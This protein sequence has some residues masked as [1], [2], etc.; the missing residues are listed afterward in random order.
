LSQWN[1]DHDWEAVL[2]LDRRLAA[3]WEEAR[4]RQALERRATLESATLEALQ[5]HQFVESWVEYP[6][7]EAI[8]GT[9]AILEELL[10]ELGTEDCVQ[11]EA[12][13][14][15]VLAL[16]ALDAKLKYFIETM[17]REAL[18]SELELIAYACGAPG[19]FEQA[20]ERYREW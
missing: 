15:A 2:E 17:E 3:E 12:F 8:R 13:K 11:F 7:R 6:S 1:W 20:V 4:E 10:R 16:N 9:R 18:C 5:S 19:L 14:R